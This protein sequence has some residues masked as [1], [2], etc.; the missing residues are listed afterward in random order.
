MKYNEIKINNQLNIKRKSSERFYSA[1]TSIQAI[2]IIEVI[3]YH[4]GLVWSFRF[5][6]NILIRTLFE[7]TESCVDIFIFL[8]GMLLTIGL[9]RRNDSKFKWSIWYKTRIVR[10]YPLLI[11]STF[12][13]IIS[14][15]YLFR[16]RYSINIIILHM[17]GLQ[18][19]PTNPDFFLIASPHWYITLI[20]SCYLLFPLFLYFIRKNAKLAAIVGV[21]LYICYLFT[22]NMIF[23]FSKDFINL[24]LH[25]NLDL[26]YY[27]LFILRFFIFFFGMLFGYWIGSDFKRIEF[28]QKKKVGIIAFLLLLLVISFYFFFPITNSTFL[29]FRRILYHPL[30][31]ILLTVFLIFFLSK[32]V[33]INNIL[34]IPGKRSYEIYLFHLIIIEILYYK[35]IEFFWLEDIL[36]IYIIL[37]PVII[38]LS[39]ISSIP[40][41][42]LS[43][44][45]KNTEK[46]HRT[47]LMLSFSLIAYAM[48]VFLFN[49]ELIINNF[50]S[51]LLFISIFF[52]FIFLNC[53]KSILIKKKNL[54]LV[55]IEDN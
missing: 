35:V 41:Y 31:T 37:I 43:K 50:Q 7:I 30:I 53:F 34:K 5:N 19:Q 33:K 39:I 40:L 11:I 8:S 15:Y 47:I 46:I 55:L 36:E 42:L 44:F 12:F 17:S 21:L 48:I 1:I 26:W 32:Q 4:I 25:R 20:L 3:I 10:I 51:V 52:T 24:I 54:N 18:S 6:S 22:A 23:G 27:S 14:N 49:L 38:I 2:A 9:I 45:F 16:D 13:F 29:D 28:L